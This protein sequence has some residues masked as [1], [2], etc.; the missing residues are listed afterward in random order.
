[1]EYVNKK[2]AICKYIFFGVLILL[3]FFIVDQIHAAT[4]SFNPS[5]GYFTT[6]NIFTLNVLVDSQSTAIND[7]EVTVSFPSNLLEV[8]SV[9]KS[10]S[11]FSLWVEDPSFS[12]SAGTVSFDG[13]VPTPG[14]TGT[15][16]KI[17][18]IVFQVKKAGIAS[19]IFSSAVVRANDGYGTNVF[20]GSTP[21]SFNLLEVKQTYVPVIP[22][23]VSIIITSTSTIAEEMLFPS[24]HITLFPAQVTE[25]N[26]FEVDGALATSSLIASSTTSTTTFT[27]D[28][29][30][31]N[32]NGATS[33]EKV[34]VNPSGTFSMVWPEKLTYGT[35]KL[36][37][38]VESFGMKSPLTSPL[39]LTV[40]EQGFARI[41]TL[42]LT[43][44]TY[45]STFIL[46]VLLILILIW[47]LLYRFSRLEKKISKKVF[48]AEST[49]YKDFDYIRKEIN[50]RIDFLQKTK[51][52]RE[53]TDQ[54]TELLNKLETY[55]QVIEHDVEKEFKGFKK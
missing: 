51:N 11:I 29:F 45:N 17:L 31:V 24:L 44:F 41:E 20:T 10:D 4:L 16:G 5:S 23:G 26:T 32:E 19:V 30:L 48:E 53:L 14:F 46:I 18:S 2:K 47:Y 54:E 6:G 27:A 36:Y 13:G 37:G 9:S 22:S 50:D 3:N 38:E 12:N 25:G 15:A 1:M 49:L 42:L 35:Y 52:E 43:Y 28:L 7:A 40:T 39:F 21:A 33:T 8:M 55:L 34:T